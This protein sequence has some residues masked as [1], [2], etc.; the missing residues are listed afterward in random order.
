MAINSNKNFLCSTVSV[1][2]KFRFSLPGWLCCRSLIRF[3]SRCW[4]GLQSSG[5]VKGSACKMAHSSGWQV[6]A[7]LGRTPQFI[8]I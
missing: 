3:Q 1:A 6:G 8:S 4:L 2:Q 7:D 5:G